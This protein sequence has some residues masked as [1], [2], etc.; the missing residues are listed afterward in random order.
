MAD[1]ATGMT[2]D[3]WRAWTQEHKACYEVRPLMHK[4]GDQLVQVGFEFEIAVC[5]PEKDQSGPREQTTW[6]VLGNLA[7]LTKRVFPVEGDIARFEL[8]PFQ[9]VAQLRKET[10][11]QPEVRRVVQVYHKRK[12]FQTVAEA[13]RQRLNPLEGQLQDLGVKAGSW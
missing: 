3:D 7:Y 5:L 13:D 6:D 4:Q 8:A 12:Y 11:F 2:D 10:G 9:P 1:I